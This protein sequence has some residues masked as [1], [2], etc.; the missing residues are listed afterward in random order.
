MKKNALSDPRR[1]LLISRAFPPHVGGMERLSYNVITGVSRRMPIRTI[2]N[3]HGKLWLPFFLLYAL[4]KALLVSPRI[5]IVHLGDPVLAI[6][7]F[8]IK[9]IYHRKILLCTVHGLDLLYPSKLYQWYLKFFLSPD[10]I[11]CISHYT[12]M[13]ARRAGYANVVVI[14]PGLD[15]RDFTVSGLSDKQEAFSHYLIPTDKKVILTVGRLVKRKGVAWFIEN[16]FMKC[17]DDC[18]Y[19]VVGAGPEKSII[20]QAVARAGF[21]HRIFLLGRVSQQVLNSLYVHADI[22]VMPNIS[23]PNDA[24]GF[25]FVAL[26]AAAWG[27]PVVAA[28]IEGIVDA[29]VPGENGILVRS[30][31]AEGFAGAI[32]SLLADPRKMKEIG[33]RAREFTLRNYDWN[34]IIGEYVRE[35]NSL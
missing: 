27:R 6:V 31:D 2:L 11:I 29:I 7:G 33:Q 14:P 10:R 9:K 3:R 18:V 22:F 15:P 23:V 26:E 20:A 5:D 21:G 16:V 25:G 24:E 17:P 12:A 28:R 32:R 1:V 35:F 34:V 30:E 4:I 19:I 13:L 8:F